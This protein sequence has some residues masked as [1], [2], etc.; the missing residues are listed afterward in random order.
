MN[1]VLPFVHTLTR[2]SLPLPSTKPISRIA[3]MSTSNWASTPPIPKDKRPIVLSGPSGVGK[4]T[5]LKKLFEEFP[6]DFGFSVSRKS[7]LPIHIASLFASDIV[8]DLVM[9]SFFSNNCRYNPRPASRRNPRSILPLRLPPRIRTTHL[10]RCIPRTRPIWRQPLRHHRKS[11]RR[12]IHR[13]HHRHR[14]LL[15]RTSSYPR[16]RRS[17]CKTYQSQSP[18]P[19]PDLYLY[20]PSIFFDT[21]T[22]IDG[23][24]DRDGRKCEEKI[25]N[26]K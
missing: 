9:N 13:R 2:F 22:K 7:P 16:Y 24:G 21:Q 19:K 1:R 20:L 17:R 18:F 3:T 23:K 8:A 5:L 12:R 25:D 10:P 6:N 11:R 15:Q 4:S 14:R 26:G